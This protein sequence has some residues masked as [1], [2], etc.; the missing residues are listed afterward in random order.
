MSPADVEKAV[1]QWK[2]PPKFSFTNADIFEAVSDYLR[3][4]G[5]KV[6]QAGVTTSNGFVGGSYQIS[7]ASDLRTELSDAF[8]D[9][10]GSLRRFG[11][12]VRVLVGQGD[13]NWVEVLVEID[14]DVPGEMPKAR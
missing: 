13:G 9:L 4:S 3:R 11:K 7:Y 5:G 12:A 1:D 6:E 10:T 14:S 8:Q 2:N